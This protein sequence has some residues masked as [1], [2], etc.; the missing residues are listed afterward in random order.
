MLRSV[1]HLQRRILDDTA[2][3]TEIGGR[4][5]YSTCSVWLDE[6]QR[7]AAEFAERHPQYCLVH[8]KTV[9]PASE[10]P[11]RYHDGGYVAVFERM[12]E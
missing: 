2:P 5:A 4:L 10:S 12:S 8:E 1:A 3:A 6:N 11:A 7:I 9:L